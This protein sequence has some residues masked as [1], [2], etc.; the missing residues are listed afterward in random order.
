MKGTRASGGSWVCSRVA[1]KH[2]PAVI[3]DAAMAALDL[4][5]PTYRFLRRSPSPAI[6]SIAQE[7]RNELS[8]SIALRR[9]VEDSE[10]LASNEGCLRRNLFSKPSLR[11]GQA[12][13]RQS[14]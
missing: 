3:K 12:A 14:C 7:T 10:R 9:E 2:G 6:S 13:G 11:A 4:G 8:N 1:K 5:V